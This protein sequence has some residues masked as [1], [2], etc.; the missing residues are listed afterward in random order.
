MNDS[1]LDM[2]LKELLKREEK[3]IPDAGFSSH[4]MAALPPRPLPRWLRWGILLGSGIIG[5]LIT[6]AISSGAAEQPV[7]AFHALADG[8][9]N[10]VADASA[11]MAVSPV[12]LTTAALFVCGIAV[13][14]RFDR[15]GIA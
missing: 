2:L 11:Y 15:E 12:F 10:H 13:M 1:E 8:L 14:F 5:L 9:F 6:A 7:T 4:V 3:E